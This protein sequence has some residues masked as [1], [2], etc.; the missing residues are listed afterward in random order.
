[1]KCEERFSKRLFEAIALP[2]EQIMSL[3]VSPVALACSCGGRGCFQ[4]CLAI[5][6][7]ENNR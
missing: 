2:R 7:G 5:W 3:N 1:M 6:Q 4:K